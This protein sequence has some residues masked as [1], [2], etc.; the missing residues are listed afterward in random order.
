MKPTFKT[1]L[2]E[3][4]V[5]KTL[6]KTIEGSDLVRIGFEFEC[7][8][9]KTYFEEKGYKISADLK[10][11]P[12]NGQKGVEAFA[13]YAKALANEMHN[14]LKLEMNVNADYHSKAKSMTKW[15]LEPDISISQG[16]KGFGVEIVSPPLVIAEALEQLEALFDFFKKYKIETND[17]TG[18][19]VNM[20]V[21]GV[22]E[23]N[24]LK[25]V[26]LGGF[27]FK[28]KTWKRDDNIYAQSNFDP[29]AHID[30]GDN[31]LTLIDKRRLKAGIDNQ[32]MVKIEDVIKTFL[33][34]NEKYTQVNDSNFK[35]KKYIEFRIAG[36]KDYHTFIDLIKHDVF[37]YAS[38]LV[39]A[40]NEDLYKK[41]YYAKLMNMAHKLLSLDDERS[42]KATK[43]M[44]EKYKPSIE[45]FKKLKSSLATIKKQTTSVK[46][47][48]HID[49]MFNDWL[50]PENMFNGKGS[51]MVLD[52]YNV[53]NI[54]DA[55]VA[56][57]FSYLYSAEKKNAKISDAAE[58]WFLILFSTIA[59]IHTFAKGTVLEDL[60]HSQKKFARTFIDKKEGQQNKEFYNTLIKKVIE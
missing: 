12:V 36:G 4:L 8:V 20:S 19:H 54:S 21:K 2:T 59:G 24:F 51:A 17:T 7:V 26:M 43:D 1:Y 28:S 52:R 57:L 10:N 23:L 48:E 49:E 53:S 18:L 60:K 27:N 3:K 22:E 42:V 37:D 30:S 40:A 31:D 47:K 13:F 41:E 16:K 32:D 50:S 55:A 45:K 15:T 14:E 11:A 34:S 35:Q 56:A 29:I 58:K 6:I 44:P 9:P 25:L 39:I 33:I 46:F 38:A 5:S